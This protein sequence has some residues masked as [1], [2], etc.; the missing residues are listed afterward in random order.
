MPERREARKTLV[1]VARCQNRRRIPVATQHGAACVS[2]VSTKP[3]VFS[4]RVSGR[5]SG[6]KRFSKL[7]FRKSRIVQPRCQNGYPLPKHTYPIKPECPLQVRARAVL[8][9]KSS[10][11]INGGQSTLTPQPF[12]RSSHALPIR[13]VIR[14]GGLRCERSKP[15][16]FPRQRASGGERWP[17]SEGMCQRLARFGAHWNRSVTSLVARPSMKS[18]RGRSPG[19]P[20]L[21]LILKLIWSRPGYSLCG[22]A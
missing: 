16:I 4:L 12:P 9:R 10:N 6:W 11:C 5:K 8:G 1:R 21:A 17:G 14:L 15:D 20:G 22:P 2:A 18:W 13:M 19:M 3:V 7:A